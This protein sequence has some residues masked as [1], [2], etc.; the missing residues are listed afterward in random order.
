MVGMFDLPLWFVAG[1]IVLL[2]CIMGSFLDVFISRFH[3]G[4]SIN[5]RSH[6]TS[7]GHTLDWY[8][9]FPVFSY[10]F[11][12]GRC[13]VCGA[14]IPARLFWMEIATGALFLLVLMSADSN[15]ELLFGIV[16]VLIA[17]VIT[18]YDI[19]HLVIP[20]M[21]TLAVGVLAIFFLVYTALQMQSL[22]VAV[23]Y[24]VSGIIAASF[25]YLLWLISGGRW[26][27]KGDAKLALPLGLMLTAK[28]TFSFVVLSFWVGAAVSVVLLLAQYLLVRGQNHLR[29]LRIPLTMKSEVPF[30]PFLLIAFA[31]VYFWGVD[32]LRLFSIII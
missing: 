16:F 12:R 30:A 6:C 2:G 25:Y 9:L 3:T 7:C 19:R 23:P 8:E 28:Q 13:L 31:L 29:F 26:I 22:T 4:K 27:G 21:F 1:V 5:G 18:V 15:F 10:L 17:I 24:V 11:L 32:V 14:K 20:D